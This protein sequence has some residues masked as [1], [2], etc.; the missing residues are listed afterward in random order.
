VLHEIGIHIFGPSII[1]L[2]DQ[3]SAIS[4]AKNA[5]HH[6]STNQVEIDQQC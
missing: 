3:Q 2:C 6:G 4:I 5:L 1:V